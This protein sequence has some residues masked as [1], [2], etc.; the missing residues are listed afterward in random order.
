VKRQTDRTDEVV[1]RFHRAIAERRPRRPGFVDHLM[2]H[3]MRSLYR[4]LGGLD[5]VPYDYTYWKERGMFDPVKKY[6]VEARNHGLFSL[7]ARLMA[8]SMEGQVRKAL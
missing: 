1:E 8:G 7:I 5:P 6:F 4:H 3:S 2:F